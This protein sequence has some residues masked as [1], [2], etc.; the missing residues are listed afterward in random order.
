MHKTGYTNYC[1]L[2]SK[3]TVELQ[4]KNYSIVPRKRINP[5]I[6]GVN[7]FFQVICCHS[8]RVCVSIKY[9][10]RKKYLLALMI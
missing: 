1:F 7:R 5:H 3:T 4:L 10:T 8:V 6:T 9:L 2:C